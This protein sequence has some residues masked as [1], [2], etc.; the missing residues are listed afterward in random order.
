MAW[1]AG[2][3]P[4]TKPSAML[5]PKPMSK[6]RAGKK[7]MRQQAGQCRVAAR[8][9]QP[10]QSQTDSSA[11]DREQARLG[12]HERD[13]LP[14]GKTDGL[15]HA[16]F[17]GPLAHGLRHG[18]A[19]HEQDGEEYRAQ[20][21]RDNED[22]VADL[23]GPALNERAFRLRLGFRRRIFKFRVHPFGHFRRLRRILD[24]DGV[25]ADLSLARAA[26]LH[27]NNRSG[28]TAAWCRCL[29]LSRRKCPRCQMSRSGFRPAA[30]RWWIGWAPCR[31]FSSG[32]VPPS[33]GRRSR[34]SAWP[35]RP[36]P[37][38]AAG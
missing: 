34:P 17:A 6:A 9:D 37:V 19:G 27:Q 20:N 36:S 25:P 10:R 13:D 3:I 24:A 22:D 28:K 16:Q 26:A 18:V 38:P 5:M 21:R 33:G 12:E 29:C 31:R 1:S 15:E 4:V 2:K 7:N 35:A 23:A 8:N 11:E 14:V 30:S 32:T